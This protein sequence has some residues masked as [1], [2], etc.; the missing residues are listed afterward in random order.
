MVNSS[1]DIISSD[2]S[3][4]GLMWTC[5]PVA[6]SD[7]QTAENLISC[8]D[9]P[10]CSNREDPAGEDRMRR[11]RTFTWC[12]N[13]KLVRNMRTDAELKGLQTSIFHMLEQVQSTETPE[14]PIFNPA[15][16]EGSITP[17][18]NITGSPPRGHVLM[19]EARSDP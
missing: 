6:N 19:S 3:G 2:H 5:H 11:T 13:I 14:D 8:R 1:E 9:R 10:R 4:P 15:G 18:L 12:L 7:L 17:E 16:L